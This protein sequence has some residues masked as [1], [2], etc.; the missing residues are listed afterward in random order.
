MNK[1]KH[2]LLCLCILCHTNEHM[3]YF[4]SC[5]YVYKEAKHCFATSLYA[6]KLH[7]CDNQT[8]IARC[9]SYR[10]KLQLV[11]NALFKTFN[12]SK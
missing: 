6:T 5:S 2:L 9:V 1:N 10:M 11:I 3:C 12:I 8:L 7:I 4:L